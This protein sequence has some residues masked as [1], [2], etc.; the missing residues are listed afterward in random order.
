MRRLDDDGIALAHAARQMVEEKEDGRIKLY[1]IWRALRYRRGHAQLFSEGEYIPLATEG[2]QRKHVVAFA[3]S[4]ANESALVCVP[5]LIAQLLGSPLRSPLGTEVWSDTLLALPA[6]GAEK[7]YRNL[8][9][10]EVLPVI[11]SNGA[12]S[13]RLAD[14]FAHFPVA[15]LVAGP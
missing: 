9:T 5:R 15:M 6:N 1:L 14:V 13:L 12:R 10:G 3:R 11:E 8:F 4:H 7:Q 2:A